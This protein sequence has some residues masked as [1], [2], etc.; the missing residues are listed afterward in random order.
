MKESCTVHV[1]I[2][3]NYFPELCALTIPTIKFW[4]KK[5]NAKLNIITTRKFLDWPILYEK[6]QVFEDGQNSDWNILLDA[7][8]LVHPRTLN[9]LNVNV[10]P[11]QVGCRITYP[12]HNLLQTDEFFIK[13]GR[14]LGLST[15]AVI[16]SRQCHNL[17]RPLEMT[18]QEACEKI[19]IER[20]VV[21]EYTISRNLAKYG[22]VV[23]PP[24]DPKLDFR[25]FFH[26]GVYGCD[27]DKVL[28]KA[29]EWYK[30]YF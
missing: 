9:P 25:K 28:D 18:P 16:T 13:D 26:L 5:L 1:V 6:M 19:L 14:D 8:T 4:A 29:K 27:K 7:D 15:S 20:K 21:D 23:V 12:A 30:R 17:W 22:W 24:M 2:I 3:D 10:K 11:N